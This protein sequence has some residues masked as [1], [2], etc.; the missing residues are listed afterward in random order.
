MLPS[1]EE[2]QKVMKELDIRK[3]DIIV[4]YDEVNHLFACRVAWM[5]RAFGAKKACVLDGVQRGWWMAKYPVDRDQKNNEAFSRKCLRF[6]EPKGADYD[7]TL[8]RE[9]VATY[10]QMEEI[11]YG[12]SE[13]VWKQ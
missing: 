2:F 7:F 3:D 11:V 12:D 5:L 1:D 13:D 4:C 10:D 6:L 9:K 8:N